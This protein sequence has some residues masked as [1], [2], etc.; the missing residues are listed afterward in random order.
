M[1][2]P[3]PVGAALDRLLRSLVTGGAPT[4]EGVF[5]RWQEVVGSALAEHSVPRSLDDGCLVVVADDPAW[6][7]SLRWLE[8]DLIGRLAGVV[9]PGLVRR[10]EVRVEGGRGGPRRA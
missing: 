4:V 9:G 2:V 7:S 5:G 10:V 3:R 6:A 1:S 8:R